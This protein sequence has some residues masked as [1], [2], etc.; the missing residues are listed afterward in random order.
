MRPHTRCALGPRKDTRRWG[1]EVKDSIYEPKLFHGALR[2]LLRWWASS[3][4]RKQQLMQ[5]PM[6]LLRIRLAKFPLQGAHHH[7]SPVFPT[8]SFSLEAEA[9]EA[10]SC[11][12][13]GS[14]GVSLWAAQA[15]R[16]GGGGMD[17]ML[18]PRR[19]RGQMWSLFI[20][21]L[22]ACEGLSSLVWAPLRAFCRSCLGSQDVQLAPQQG[23]GGYWSSRLEPLSQPNVNLPSPSLGL[24]HI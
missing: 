4:L 2:S 5:G 12:T 6:G 19:P 9:P 7:P 20:P 16:G 15:S 17:K 21:F 10:G 1:A 13:H 3:Q 23:D 18:H 11:A 14:F 8:C 24:L 22:P